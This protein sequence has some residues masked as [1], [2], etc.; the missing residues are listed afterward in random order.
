MYIYLFQKQMKRLNICVVQMDVFLR[1]HTKNATQINAIQVGQCVFANA[2]N[3][4]K[5]QK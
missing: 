3:L 2:P 5:M 1:M 4:L